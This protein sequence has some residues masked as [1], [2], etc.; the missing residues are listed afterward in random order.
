MLT[1][2]MLFVYER[3]LTLAASIHDDVSGSAL[4]AV[5]AA[6]V[7]LTGAASVPGATLMQAAVRVALT[8]DTAS[9]G[10]PGIAVVTV[11]TSG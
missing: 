5:S 2:R 8:R 3:A 7:R 4:G 11:R 9:A 6:Y 10:G 1:K